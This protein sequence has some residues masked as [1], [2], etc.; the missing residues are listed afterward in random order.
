MD[1]RGHI[2]NGVVVLDGN[3]N[4]PEGAAVI[5]SIPATVPPSPATEI[6]RS[7]GKLPYVHGGNPG[8]WNLTNERIGQV[9]EEEDIELMKGMWNEPS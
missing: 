1:I 5:V 8:T 6:V 4:L 2:R 3:P 7:P 9:L